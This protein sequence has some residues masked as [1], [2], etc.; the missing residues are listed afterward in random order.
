[1]KRFVWRG[2]CPEEMF[3]EG[4]NVLRSY[5]ATVICVVGGVGDEELQLGR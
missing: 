4:G 5:K 2:S 1:M 3:G